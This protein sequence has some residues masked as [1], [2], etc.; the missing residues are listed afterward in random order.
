MI[1][2]QYILGFNTRLGPVFIGQTPDGRYHPVWKGQSLGAYPC[3]V[4]A[5]DDVARGRTHSPSDGTNLAE[6]EISPDIG[7]WLPADALM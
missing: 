7:W 6:L 2:M 5:I 4:A 1:G 3:A